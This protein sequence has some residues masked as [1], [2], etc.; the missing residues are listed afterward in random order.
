[1]ILID[2]SVWVDFFRRSNQQLIDKLEPLIESNEVVAVSCV[3]GELLQ[4]ARN[5]SE[6]KVIL[7]FWSALLKVDETNLFIE[8]GKI[9]GKY[10]L[11]NRGIGLIETYILAAALKYNIPLLT[12]NKTLVKLIRQC[13]SGKN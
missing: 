8:T 4:G 1:V 12:L 10:K 2:T 9:S 3:F 11:F 13:Y 7:D 6:E 5:E